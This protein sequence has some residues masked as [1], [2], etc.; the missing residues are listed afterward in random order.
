MISEPRRDDLITMYQ[1]L[2]S[3]AQRAAAN[4][5]DD[6]IR[7]RSGLPAFVESVD[8]HMKAI[9]EPFRLGVVGMFK[10]GKSTI[11][12]TFLRRD[13]LKEGRTETTSVLTE[14]L[15][16]DS[17]EHERGEIVFRD[18]TIR[19]CQ[20]ISE[21]LEF[22][23][24]RSENFKGNSE[25]RR[26]E[27]RKIE[28]VRIYLHAGLLQNLVL[29]DTP[30]FGGS[31]IGDVMAFESLNH[32]DAALM[33]FS[34]DRAGAEEELRIANELNL[35]GREVV[36]VLNQ[37]DNGRGEMRKEEALHECEQFIRG[38]FRTLVRG[39][40]GEPLIFRYSAL[41]V[42]NVHAKPEWSDADMESLKK[43]G[44]LS[45]GEKDI[46]KGAEQ[47][48]CDRYFSG[49]TLARRQKMTAA[50]TALLS[51]MHRLL[52]S[53]ANELENTETRHKKLQTSISEITRQ[54]EQ[55]VLSRIPIIETELEDEIRT[56]VRE[57]FRRL[58]DAI[59]SLL[60]EMKDFNPLDA[61]KSQDKLQKEF[62]YRF[63]CIF[64]ESADELLV[65]KIVKK[66][67]N[68]FCH[69]WE[70]I[71]RDNT[72]LNLNFEGINLNGL[73]SKVNEELHQRI[74]QLGLLTGSTIVSLFVPG[75][76]VL[77]LILTVAGGSMGRDPDARLRRKIAQAQRQVR[78]RLQHEADRT[79]QGTLDQMIQKNNELADK[80][81]ATLRSEAK[82]AEEESA[83]LARI[84]AVLKHVGTTFEDRV[85]MVLEYEFIVST[86]EATS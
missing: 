57:Y 6:S 2:I 24:I 83:R 84:L 30:G 56:L 32:V 4:I 13:I 78:N 39:D 68:V 21:A 33:I 16:A 1:N 51:E 3:E 48:M 9:R 69:H 49:E 53:S 85:R 54:I 29:V 81:T 11:L 79:L 38:N 60:E 26:Q 22:T 67:R 5:V 44:Y 40:D 46:D 31:E 75:G 34:A 36:A 58:A 82:P 72:E 23:D 77:A 47:F 59:D 76:Q 71:G 55:R 50:K 45:K 19:Q 25:H 7:F 73:L 28:R 70:Q 35:K 74:A 66:C 15:F 10:S 37:C 64:P 65:R 80:V 14:I 17:P 61:L 27:Q 41:E 42:K 18:G 20:G 63:R 43:W 62:N 8:A 86:A 12:N 52:A